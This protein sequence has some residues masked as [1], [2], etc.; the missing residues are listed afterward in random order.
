MSDISSA[1]D[2]EVRD[3]TEP[4]GR[5]NHVNAVVFL[6]ESM[7][8][9]GL[10]IVIRDRLDRP[11]SDINKILFR[12]EGH[13]MGRLCAYGVCLGGDI[14]LE[15]HSGGDSFYMGGFDTKL[16]GIAV[17]S[18][19]S[20]RGGGCRNFLNSYTLDDRGIPLPIVEVEK[21]NGSV[22]HSVTTL[23]KGD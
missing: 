13:A 17:G 16:N 9:A 5:G 22:M 3:Q 6:I 4:C 14:R 10:E 12:L 21:S 15:A 1:P 11:L 18:A 8:K 20:F 7:I 23:R 19:G 2:L